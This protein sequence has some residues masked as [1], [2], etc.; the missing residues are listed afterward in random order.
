MKKLETFCKD[1]LKDDMI[2]NLT[3]RLDSCVN[4]QKIFEISMYIIYGIYMLSC[5]DHLSTK[6]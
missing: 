3:F 1:F 2:Y 4:S 6:H 5:A